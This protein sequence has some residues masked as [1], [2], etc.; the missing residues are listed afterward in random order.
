MRVFRSPTTEPMDATQRWQLLPDAAE[1]AV[2]DT[3][4]LRQYELG[5]FLTFLNERESLVPMYPAAE[6]R[7][8]LAANGIPHNSE[9]L[10]TALSKREILGMIRDGTPAPAIRAALRQGRVE[11]LARGW[12]E[13]VQERHCLLYTSPSPR[14]RT[15]SRMPSSA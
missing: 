4:E 12:K 10:N 2:V 13:I 3:V 1:P 14:D 8:I 6:L 9:D 5:A 7:L 15:R 11:E